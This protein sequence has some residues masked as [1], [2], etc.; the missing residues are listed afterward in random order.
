M[1]MAVQPGIVYGAFVVRCWYSAG[2]A[3]RV[4]VE[5]VQGRTSVRLS[6]LEEAERWM[7]E[8]MNQQAG[9]QADTREAEPA[10][11]QDEPKLPNEEPATV[12]AR[13]EPAPHNQMGLDHA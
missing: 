1:A 5:H 3:L 8:R 7:T 4:D 9:G 10:A 13:A 11:P 2:R 12:E 6:S